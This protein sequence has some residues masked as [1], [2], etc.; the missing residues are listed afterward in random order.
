ME[1]T[2]CAPKYKKFEIKWYEGGLCYEH[3]HEKLSITL[4]R[5][6]FERKTIGY[7]EVEGIEGHLSDVKWNYKIKDL[8]FEDKL[9]ELC[10][11]F[12]RVKDN[13][14]RVAGCDVATFTIEV[15]PYYGDKT[16]E[17]YMCNMKE[18]G[19]DEVIAL[20]EKFLP[21]V[22]SRPYFF[23]EFYEEYEEE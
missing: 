7:M 17:Y 19:L 4:D 23:E 21:Q 5:V 3:S 18:N 8:N 9:T 12:L 16:I 20:L 15:I 22:A 13:T 6:S 11:L 2:R 14:I 1:E 10:D